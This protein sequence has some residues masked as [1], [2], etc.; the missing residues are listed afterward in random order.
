MAGR[1]AGGL[2]GWC[3]RALATAL[4]GIWGLLACLLSC[5]ACAPALGASQARLVAVVRMQVGSDVSWCL[6]RRPRDSI[7]PHPAG[8]GAA[9]AGAAG[10]AAAQ[11]TGGG[12]TSPPKARSGAGA[13]ADKPMP[14]GAA[15]WGRPAAGVA[16]AGGKGAASSAAGPADA[17]ELQRCSPFAKFTTLSDPTPLWLAAAEELA[18]YAIQVRAGKSFFRRK[19]CWPPRPSHEGKASS[20]GG[21]EGNAIVVGGCGAG[22]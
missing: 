2:A 6:L 15:P 11:A 14:P 4:S 7:I 10:A 18:Q 12:A 20:L 9:P 8:A 22:Q 3:M 5:K 13:G 21:R 17:G 1:L 19:S 16:G